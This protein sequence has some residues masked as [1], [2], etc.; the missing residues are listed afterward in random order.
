MRRL[1]G[2]VPLF[3]GCLL[4]FPV[5]AQAQATLA[6]V[7]R[8][9]TGAVLP[10]VTVEATSPVLIEKARTAVTDGSGQYRITDLEPGIYSVSFT[11]SGFNVTKRDNLEVRGSG[12]IPINAELRIG[13]LQET[14]TVTGESP[15]VDTQ[16]TRRETVLTSE[17]L[18]TLPATRT[19]GALLNAIP[20]LSTNTG[21]LGAM[22][23]PDMTFFTANGGRQNGGQVQ[24][25]GMPVAASF[26]GGGVSTFTY[27]VANAAEMQVLVSGGLG[28]AENGEPRI[29]LV[30][31][32]G[33]NAFRG[34]GFYSGA[35]KWSASSNISPE[36]TA[37]GIVEPPT[38]L[39]LWDLS[40]SYSGPVVRDRLWFFGSLRQYGNYQVVEGVTTN[41]LAGNDG[42]WAYEAATGFQARTANSRDIFSG[43]FTG[44]I[45]DRNRLSVYHEYQHRCSG[46]TATADGEGCRKPGG[47]W[48]GLGTTTASPESWPGYHD[49]PYY[50]TQIAW[51]SPLSNRLLLEAGFSRFH[52]LWAGFGQ[53]PPD[54][55]DLIP[56][57]ETQA[58][59]GHRASFQYRGI[60]D[61]IAYAYADNDANPNNWKAAASYVTGSHNVKFGYQ[62]SLQRSLQ[63]RE[64]NDTL[65]VYRF[66]H[67]GT[68]GDAS[69]L[70]RLRLLHRPAVGD[71]RPDGDAVALRSGSVDER[72]SDGAGRDA[73][74]PGV[75]L[76]P[77]R[78]QRHHAD[79]AV[80]SDAEDVRTH[81][82]RRG[83]QRHHHAVGCGVGRLRHRPDGAEGEHRQVP[84]DGDQRRELRD[85]QSGRRRP[86]R[87]LRPQPELDRRRRRPRHRLQ[88]HELRGA[89]PGDRVGRHLRRGHRQQPELR[90]PE[91]ERH[92]CEP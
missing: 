64:A 43:R 90:Q 84:A 50:V 36:L 80:Q 78:K 74:R 46:T 4:L 5:L 65:L 28:E 22:A 82:Q 67:D 11:L 2:V 14:I 21:S 54:H 23:T 9:N 62:G 81:G 56:V 19:Y 32:S 83:L 89:E 15:L 41:R 20:G 72:P 12:V 16:T 75:E 79:L 51:T 77:G 73:L 33:G 27:D 18:Q 76:G 8:D 61:P 63:G 49:F 68:S 58:R 66:E 3:V 35:G 31:Q 47:D 6:G 53:A 17:T 86:V 29:N 40:G 69:E 7:V 45:T 30:P 85:Q 52:Y 38:I 59:D 87:H 60:F 91:S 10:G 88:H 25:D 92:A 34:Q 24:I 55:L 26:N 42:T 1:R 57:V 48:I 70:Q 71:Q 44:Q 39:K 37:V 13:A